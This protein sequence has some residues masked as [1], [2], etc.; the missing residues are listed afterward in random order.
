[1]SKIIFFLNVVMLHIKLEF[2]PSGIRLSLK[3][4]I[5]FIFDRLKV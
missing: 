5:Y 3:Q 1:M 4:I 2:N